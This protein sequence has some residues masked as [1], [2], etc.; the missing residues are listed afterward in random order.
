[1][2]MIY[3]IFGICLTLTVVVISYLNLPKFGRPATGERLE[4]IQQSPNYHEGKFYNQ[5]VTPQITGGKSYP[6]LIIDFLFTKHERN[7]PDEAIPTLKN[8]LKALDRSHELLVWFGHSSY[9]IQSAG[10]RILVDPVFDEAS[11]LSFFNK[12]FEG[13]EI[14]KATDMPAIDYLVI[15]HDHW[16]H[17]DYRSVTELRERVTKVICPLGVGAHFDLWGY[18][19]EQ[20]V[21]MDW[22]ETYIASDGTHIHCLPARHF[23]GRSFK[24]NQTLWASYMVE[25]DTQTIYLSGDS[26]YG[27]HIAEI[28]EQFPTIDLAIM[29]N[30]QYNEAW[31]YIHFMPEDLERAI[32]ELNPKRLF[33]G[34]NSK[35]ALAYHPWDEPMNRAENFNAITMPLIGEVVYLQKAL[36]PVNRW[37]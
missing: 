29:E 32:E 18:L 11:P 4:R 34:H 12:P 26:G 21:E 27:K 31:R 30:G 20:I 25:T 37:W 35:Y 7:R 14:Y 24:S 23:S 36:A 33:A 9:F 13:T 1:M 19:P 28:A 16:D 5:E 3:L 22:N 15:S 8:D 17:L 2:R 10:K 6:S